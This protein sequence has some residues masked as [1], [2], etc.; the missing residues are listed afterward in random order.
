[1]KRPGSPEE[2]VRANYAF[3]AASPEAMAELVAAARTIALG[4]GEYLFRSGGPSD[5]VCILVDGV[6]EVFQPSDEKG[7]EHFKR[8]EPEALVGETQIVT[9]G[10]HT[11][12]VRAV[13]PAELVHISREAIHRAIERDPAALDH[14]TKVVQER[15]RRVQVH[16]ALGRLVRTS[17]KEVVEQLAARAQ[18]LHLPR[19]ELLMQKGDPADCLYVVVSGR[20]QAF[21]HDKEGQE[22]ILGQIGFGETVG[23]MALLAD[24]HRTAHVKALRDCDLA[25][26][27]RDEFMEVASQHPEIVVTVARG[28]ISRLSSRFTKST[29]SR[30]PRTFAIVPA[31]PQV[32]VQALAKELAEEMAKLGNTRLVDHESARADLGIDAKNITVEHSHNALLSAW[33]A[34]Q[35]E[36]HDYIL[37]AAEGSAAPWLERCARQADLVLLV[38]EATADPEPGEMETGLLA[39]VA[40][41]GRVQT[42]LLLLHA[43]GTDAPTETARWLAGRRLDAHYHLGLGRRGDVARVARHITGN[44]VG[45]VLGGGG[46]RGA[47]HIGVLRALRASGIPIDV[48]GGTSSGGGIAA[49]YAMGMDDDTILETNVD[50]FVRHNPFK[51]LTLPVISII[52]R[53]KMDELA[54]KTYGDVQIEDLWIDHFCVSCNLTRGEVEIHRRGPLWK[55]VRATSSLPGIAVPVI[56]DGEVLVDGGVVDNLPGMIMR[57][58]MEGKIVVVDVSPDEG[59]KVDIDYEDVPSG[60]RLLWNH[61]NPF[62]K[63]IQFPMISNVLQR[64]VTVSSLSARERTV[65]DADLVLRP[66]VEQYGMMEFKAV[67]EIAAN[68]YD[69]T[70]EQLRGTSLPRI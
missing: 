59:M 18:W 70:M 5:A 33:L 57:R 46:A 47:A 52:G 39:K 7:E 61:L 21:V 24:D 62:G 35:E 50:G 64:T 10:W 40:K 31:S 65:E 49:Q 67:Q 68:A 42:A 13:G 6:L 1:M 69:Y 27:G 8:V 12:D 19:G 15:L 43:A 53:K 26:I 32:S 11:H 37:L 28:L 45:V 36:R 29:G 3:A 51:R 20:L 54:R 2:I 30:R 55:A 25:R 4:D 17:K 66:P 41:T 23:E 63:S 34:G 9:G 60:W 58:F 48:I 38:A 44:A 16:D 56:Q 14:L 22:K